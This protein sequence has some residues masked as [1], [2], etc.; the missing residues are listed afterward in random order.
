MRVGGGLRLR[1]NRPRAE[2]GAP[3]LPGTYVR[4]EFNP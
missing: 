2:G 4:T 3:N 1:A